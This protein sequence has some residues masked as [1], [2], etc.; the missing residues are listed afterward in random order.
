M[1]Y[2]GASSAQPCQGQPSKASLPL[3]SPLV[4]LQC[5]ILRLFLSKCEHSYEASIMK[6]NV[7]QEISVLGLNKLG[8]GESNSG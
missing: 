7:N 5:A 4:A 2:L 8:G 3:P 6:L 1:T